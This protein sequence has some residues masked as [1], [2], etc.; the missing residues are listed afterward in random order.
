[1][2]LRFFPSLAAL[3]DVTRQIAVHRPTLR[4]RHCERANTLVLHDFVYKKARGGI[5]DV[6]GKRLRCSPRRLGCGRTAR[7]ALASRIPG[8]HYSALAVTRFIQALLV[9]LV[10]RRAYTLATGTEQARHAFRWLQTLG[11]QLGAYRSFL[12]VNAEVSITWPRSHRLRLL[13]P[14]LRAVFSRVAD[15]TAYQHLRQQSFLSVR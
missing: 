4:C 10:I 8:V 12:G 11:L 3:L 6:V 7:W 2:G 13:L 15:G 9:G 14:T 1:M 5:T